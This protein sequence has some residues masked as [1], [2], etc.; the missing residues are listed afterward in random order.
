MYNLIYQINSILRWDFA[1]SYKY[2]VAQ[3]QQ[4]LGI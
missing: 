2:I 1:L 3:H 4:E